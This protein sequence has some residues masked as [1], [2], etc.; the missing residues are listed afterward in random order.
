MLGVLYVHYTF[1][2]SMNDF[3]MHQTCRV[4]HG[5]SDRRVIMRV[6]VGLLQAVNIG[7]LTVVLSLC[8]WPTLSLAGLPRVDISDWNFATD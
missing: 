6:R 4:R 3:T 7:V 1:G 8:A 2:A 5:Q